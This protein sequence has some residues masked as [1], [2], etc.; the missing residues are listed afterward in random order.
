MLR[1]RLSSD[2]KLV[3]QGY[4]I[5]TIESVTSHAINYS[6]I[7]AHVDAG[8]NELKRVDAELPAADDTD[9]RDALIDTL[10]L[11]HHGR[12]G[13]FPS[14]F[15]TP[16]EEMQNKDDTSLDRSLDADE[17]KNWEIYWKTMKFEG[18][19]GAFDKFRKANA[20]FQIH[21][22]EL[23]SFFPR[24]RPGIDPYPAG[25]DGNEGLKRWAQDGPNITRDIR[26]AVVSLID[27][28]LA[29]TLKGKLALVPSTTRA[30]DV[31]AIVD[32]P[33]PIVLRQ[34]RQGYEYIG[35][36]Y[37]HGFMDGQAFSGNEQRQIQEFELQ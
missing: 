28:A 21:G 22:H 9:L 34:K 37:L 35:E 25:V 7:T 11:G 12:S 8:L 14:F 1:T 31:L 3:C 4:T 5:N 17:F 24:C 26:L 33:F 23:R 30:G 18:Y 20:F 16:W 36:C 19:F 13:L 32:C 10:I 2:G 29:I 6:D 15:A 27:R